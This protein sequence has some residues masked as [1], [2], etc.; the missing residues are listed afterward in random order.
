MIIYLQDLTTSVADSQCEFEKNC[1]K[2]TSLVGGEGALCC[3]GAVYSYRITKQA[4]HDLEY[5]SC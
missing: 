4:R 3:F 2:T 1:C 5:L